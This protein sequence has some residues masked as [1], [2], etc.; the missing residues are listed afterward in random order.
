[1]AGRDSSLA[2]APGIDSR[3]IRLMAMTVF[4]ARRSRSPDDTLPSA[5]PFPGDAPK[6]PRR[7]CADARPS[8]GRAG[9]A[10]RVAGDA[11][12]GDATKGVVAEA[13]DGDTRT[14]A[15]AT[16]GGASSGKHTT[17]LSFSRRRSVSLSSRRSGRSRSRGSSGSRPCVG[18][19]ARAQIS[20]AVV[21]DAPATRRTRRPGPR[22]APTASPAWTMMRITAGV[23]AIGRAPARLEAPSRVLRATALPH[24]SSRLRAMRAPRPPSESPSSSLPRI[25]C[26]RAGERAWVRT[27]AIQSRPRALV[28]RTVPRHSVSRL[29]LSHTTA[30]LRR[31][32]FSAPH[33][34]THTHTPPPPPTF[35]PVASHDPANLS[36]VRVLLRNTSGPCL[37][38]ICL[39]RRRRPRLPPPLSRR[40][41]PSTG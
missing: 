17:T 6:M 23:S 12:G 18:P 32:R 24:V 33:T 14:G 15:P 41:C 1:M 36:L 8:I 34:H 13:G 25:P 31:P 37:A 2:P 40:P 9:D 7:P 29:S 38:R 19:T 22:F 30:P 39:T 27:R 10:A 4:T 5:P 16:A 20:R 21:H 26:V 11:G 3:C 35:Q 28:R